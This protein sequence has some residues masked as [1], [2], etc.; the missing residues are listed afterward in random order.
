MLEFLFKFAIKNHKNSC[1]RVK[2]DPILL[3][4]LK[5]DQSSLPIEHLLHILSQRY[6][7]DRSGESRIQCRS[8]CVA[9]SNN[10]EALLG[11]A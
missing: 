11:Q 8:K 6:L 4:Q 2:M 3:Q 9:F 10:D 1:Y 5:K 7:T